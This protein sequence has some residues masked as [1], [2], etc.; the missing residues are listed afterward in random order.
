MKFVRINIDD[1]MCDC[2]E[3]IN[4]R[5]IKKVMR[6]LS[7]VSKIREYMNGST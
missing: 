6:Q 5:N 3:D 4:L 1:T 7:S 2:T